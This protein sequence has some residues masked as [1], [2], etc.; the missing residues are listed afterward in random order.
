MTAP[1]DLLK[2]IAALA[3]LG[4]I[5]LLAY[6]GLFAPIASQLVDTG[7]K[8]EE[9]RVELGRL[10]SALNEQQSDGVTNEPSIRA[11]NFTMLE[12]GSDQIRAA[13]LQARVNTVAADEGIRLSSVTVLPP[14]ADD[15]LRLVGIEVQLQAS[16]KQLQGL[17]FTLEA[18]QPPLFV[19]ML[20]IGRAAD[21]N[22]RRGRELDARMTLFGAT[23][24]SGGG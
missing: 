5:L 6:A 13:A 1:A 15:E 24:K 3:I 17:L 8:I 21:S 16:L 2:K 7:D 22:V 9:Q 18:Q 10:T 4:A 12:G 20:Q 14:R 11:L 19:G 23:T